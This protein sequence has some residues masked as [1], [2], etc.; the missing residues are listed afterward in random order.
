MVFINK[1]INPTQKNLFTFEDLDK[2]TH[3][4]KSREFEALLLGFIQQYLL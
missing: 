3:L 1:H 2:H 4:F